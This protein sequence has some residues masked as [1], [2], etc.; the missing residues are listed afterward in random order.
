MKKLVLTFAALA[1][2]TTTAT[3]DQWKLPAKSIFNT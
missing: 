2:M 1:M 3:A